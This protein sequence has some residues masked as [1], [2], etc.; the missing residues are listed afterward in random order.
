VGCWLCAT[1]AFAVGS[2][3][4]ALQAVVWGAAGAYCCDRLSQILCF[5]WCLA[6]LDDGTGD[7]DASSGSCCFGDLRGCGLCACIYLASQPQHSS[8]CPILSSFSSLLHTVNLDYAVSCLFSASP[9]NFAPITLIMT[10]FRL[11]LFFKK[12]IF[13]FTAVD[14]IIAP[15]CPISFHFFLSSALA[16]TRTYHEV[17]VYAAVPAATDPDTD[18]AH[19]GSDGWDDCCG[20]GDDCHGHDDG[21]G[22]G[23]GYGERFKDTVGGGCGGLGDC[24]RTSRNRSGSA[25]SSAIV[26]SVAAAVCFNSRRTSYDTGSCPVLCKD[27]CMT[28][29]SPCITYVTPIDPLL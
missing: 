8:L 9:I 24:A 11:S 28:L 17:D 15:L 25:A 16:W 14:T 22:Y 5:L 21:S 7:D 1:A 6:F 13:S 18:G 29:S 3:S 20:C 19:N 4:V 10:C 27:I 2:V 12:P 26:I 23:Y